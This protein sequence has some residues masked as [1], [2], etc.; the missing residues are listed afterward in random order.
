MKLTLKNG[1]A[2]LFLCLLPLEIDPTSKDSTETSVRFVWGRG[3]YALIRRGCEGQVLEKHEVPFSEFGASFEHKFA[4]P[5]RLGIRGS[6]LFDKK[7]IWELRTRFVSREIVAINP[8]AN[9]EWKY[10]ALGGGYFWAKHPLPAMEQTEIEPSVS[11]Y[12][13]LGNPRTFYFSSSLFHGIPLYSG[14]YFQFGLG[15][16]KNP[17]FDWWLG[18]GLAGPYDGGG[19]L[20]V[21]TNIRLQR[22]FYLNVLTRIGQSEGIAEGAVSL[23]LSYQ[24]KD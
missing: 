3:Q 9:L 12:L 19:L 17:N 16:R 8:F 20:L 13:R 7:Q 22:Q 5:V 14:G 4:S 21:K 1:F 2:F 11:G 23:G 18:W 15:S 10:F 24:W 6:Y